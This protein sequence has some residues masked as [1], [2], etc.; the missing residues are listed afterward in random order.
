MASAGRDPE[1]LE[2]LNVAGGD[3]PG[4]ASGEK[5]LVGLKEKTRMAV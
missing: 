3:A 4:A 2:L 1:T 5:S